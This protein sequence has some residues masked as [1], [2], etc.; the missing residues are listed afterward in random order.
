MKTNRH[1]LV[2]G[3]LVLVLG[4]L[5][6]ASGMPV[7][8]GAGEGAKDPVEYLQAQPPGPGGFSTLLK[9]IKYTGL[10][11]TLKGQ[12]PFTVMAPT[13]AAFGK[14][15]QD[16][17]NAL[18]QNK[19]ELT[20]VLKY[21]VIVGKAYKISQLVGMKSV[22]TA[23]GGLLTFGTSGTA[24]SGQGQSYTPGAITNATVNGVNIT[25]TDVPVKNGLVDV[26]DAVLSPM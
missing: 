25:K 9:A 4:G 14:L 24:S 15:G 8:F 23:E 7:A 21:H 3:T 20:K 22:K 16:K 11:V 17:L 12:G 13:D 26:I 10:D 5:L 6:L 18:I 1:V 2:V 19:A